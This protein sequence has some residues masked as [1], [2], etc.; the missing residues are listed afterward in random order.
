MG[1]RDPNQGQEMTERELA[2]NAADWINRTPYGVYPMVRCHR[3]DALD[4]WWV[5]IYQSPFSKQD[6]YRT[7]AELIERAKTMGWTP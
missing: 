3:T 5:T 2:R 7:D 6:G 1:D 4:R